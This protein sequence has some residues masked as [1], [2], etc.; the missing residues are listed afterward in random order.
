MPGM[1]YTSLKYFALGLVIGLLTAPRPGVESRHVLWRSLRSALGDVL[2]LLGAQ[3]QGR[4]RTPT[5]RATG[6]V[7]EG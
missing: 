5:D 2:G 4:V 6:A 1:I 3:A 7:I